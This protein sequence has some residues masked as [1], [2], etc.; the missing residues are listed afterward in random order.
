MANLNVAHE[1]RSMA[2]NFLEP[3]CF[4][5]DGCEYDRMAEWWGTFPTSFSV[6]AR[7]TYS[8]THHMHN[9][10]VENWIYKWIYIYMYICIYIY[11]CIYVYMYI[12]IYVH[13]YIC[14]YVYMYICIYIYICINTTYSCSGC[15]F[16]TFFC[17]QQSLKWILCF[18]PESLGS[19][20][21]GL[22][23]MGFSDGFITLCQDRH[24]VLTWRTPGCRKIQA[25]SESCGRWR[26]LHTK[27]PKKS[28]KYTMYSIYRNFMSLK[29]NIYIYVYV[30]CYCM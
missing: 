4:V 15:F 20:A 13:M 17:C 2:S 25:S 30:W 29:Y 5:K 7:T 14:I 19:L 24:K 6:P 8:N 28:Q 3:P 10:H 16:N 12:C 18:S 22:C 1:I 21:I 23:S 11:I 27:S 9:V 26:R